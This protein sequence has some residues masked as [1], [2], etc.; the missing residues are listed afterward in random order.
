VEKGVGEVFSA[1][2]AVAAENHLGSP[3]DRAW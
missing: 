2:A 3:A 1:M